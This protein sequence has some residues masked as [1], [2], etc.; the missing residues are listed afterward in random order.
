MICHRTLEAALMPAD[1]TRD[2]T[3]I[4]FEVL[5]NGTIRWL[6]WDG[7]QRLYFATLD[8]K[9]L[10]EALQSSAVLLRTMAIVF[11]DEN[12]S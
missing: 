9:E 7:R 10:I 2:V 11:G 5:D 6:L 4:E 12:Q 8:R 1:G 3:K